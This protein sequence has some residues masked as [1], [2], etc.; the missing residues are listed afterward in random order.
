M[1]KIKIWALIILGLI[2][3]VPTSI[4][5]V[6]QSIGGHSIFGL[7]FGVLLP[8]LS[9]VFYYSYLKLSSRLLDNKKEFFKILSFPSVKFSATILL[10]S[11]LYL[12]LSRDILE[13]TMVFGF[14]ILTI[15]I[16]NFIFQILIY[17]FM[18]NRIKVKKPVANTVHN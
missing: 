16:P 5:I 13:S 10:I 17:T 11:I 4:Y 18:K 3:N 9:L 7:F 2:S 12:I 1:N 14:L 15:S 6:K 8:I